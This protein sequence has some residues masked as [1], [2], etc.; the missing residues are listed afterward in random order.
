MKVDYQHG[1]LRLAGAVVLT[2]AITTSCGESTEPTSPELRQVDSRAAQLPL[3][4]DWYNCTGLADGN[5]WYCV[6][7]HTE[8]TAGEP[9][10][11]DWWDPYT[12][13]WT[14]KVCHDDAL[15]CDNQFRDFSG[16]TGVH[17][18]PLPFDI[19]PSQ[20]QDPAKPTCPYKGPD[21]YKRAFC[22]GR[23]KPLS[24]TQSSRWQAALQRMRGRGAICAE[25]ADQAAAMFARGDFSLFPRADYNFNGGAPV[26]GGT[27]G[28]Y[29]WAVLDR[30]WLERWYDASHRSEGD[31]HVPQGLTL[32]GAIAHEMDHLIKG[33]Q[34][35]VIAPGDTA[36]MLTPHTLECDDPA[37]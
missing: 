23:D 5:E 34:H 24:S 11:S 2:C 33:A 35:V 14:T 4:I 28:I 3:Y 36:E 27:T 22:A 13:F 10:A 32:P 15:Y 29:S 21:D 26:N 9:A 7:S 37:P 31:E 6:F 17:S 12:E 18:R 25:F 1:P 20:G 16:R 30:T 8:Y 19:Y